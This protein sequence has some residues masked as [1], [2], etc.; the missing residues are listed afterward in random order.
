MKEAFAFPPFASSLIQI[1]KRRKSFA[2]E[3]RIL[4][5][6]DP[7][8]PGDTPGEEEDP[9]EF[10]SRTDGDGHSVEDPH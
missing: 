6:R 9:W 10:A 5:Y 7:E 1:Q 4:F 8:R 2:P 3:A